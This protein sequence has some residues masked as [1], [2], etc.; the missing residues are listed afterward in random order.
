MSWFDP[1]FVWGIGGT[2][3]G[4]ALTLLGTRLEHERAL[5]ERQR[6]NRHDAEARVREWALELEVVARYLEHYVVRRVRQHDNPFPEPAVGGRG[7]VSEFY[8]DALRAAHDRD[9]PD[10][11]R[12]VGDELTVLLRRWNATIADE[13][14]EGRA[15]QAREVAEAAEQML[16]G[17]DG[18]VNRG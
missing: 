9:L 10:G 4:G 11:V 14:P 2:I 12:E 17:L 15:V 7:D 3:V 8:L 1:T 18:G 16:R 13:D 5:R 6:R